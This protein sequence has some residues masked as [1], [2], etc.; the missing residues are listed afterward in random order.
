GTTTI[1]WTVEDIHGNTAT[2]TQDI[3]ITDNENPGITAAAA[4]TQTA[5]AGLCGAA[6]TVVAPSTADNCAVAT[7][8][9]DFNGT[10][11]ASGFYNVG[12]TTII[13]TVEDIH[14]NISTDT[15]DITV[16]DDES[17][18]A[19]CQDFTVNLDPGT[20]A[21]SIAATDI[22]NGSTDNCGITTMSVT[23]NA[24]TS[25]NLGANTVTLSIEDAAGHISTCTATVTVT[26]LTPPVAV[27]QDITV[28]LDAT[29]TASIVGTDI[30]NGSYDNGVV[31]SLDANPNTFD[32]TN[33]GVN[34]VTL[35]V[36]D[37]AG[38]TT[39]CESIV[40]VEDNIAPVMASQNVTI[41]LDAS[42]AASITPAD[43]DNGS[44]DNCDFTLTVSQTDFDC[45]DLGINTITLTGTD[46]SNNVSTITADVTV[47]DIIAPIVNCAPAQIQTA[48]AGVCEAN[49]L[50]ITP[51]V[52]DNCSIASVEND[53]N[54]ISD[55]SDIYPVGTTTI[56]WT[57]TD[58]SGNDT[59]CTQDIT[60]TDDEQ[61]SIVCAADQNQTADAGVCTAAVIVEA[62]VTDDNCGVAS[63]END[64][65]GNAD[66]SD[67]YPV[68]TTTILW[69]VTDIHGNTNT[70]TQNIVITDDE[71]PSITAAA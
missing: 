12:T 63:I 53:Y 55:A 69:T 13:W 26:D 64:Y 40:T 57:I 30:D 41:Q 59:Q 35:T 52:S 47:E 60:V 51:T 65:N 70:C 17:P 19:S 4:Q 16:T 33:V 68:G 54:S 6:V 2:C 27:C 44:Y 56:T 46:A 42:G 14:G 45:T 20:G 58:Q 11:D 34:T 28:E 67:T 10:A 62:P 61:P 5:D 48:D 37:D 9:N 36:T 32:C 43:I 29:G 8:S 31:V 3:V 18:I 66:A 50:V 21:A 38:L 71:N 24:F 7:I 49:V 25:A 15:Q 1:L 22:D 23:P 39:T